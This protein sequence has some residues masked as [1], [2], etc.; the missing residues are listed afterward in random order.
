MK[1]AI[2]WKARWIKKCEDEITNAFAKEMIMGMSKNSYV[3]EFLKWSALEQGWLALN[4]DD[5]FNS[6]Q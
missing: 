6:V 2:E 1:Q 4:V 5:S 3:T